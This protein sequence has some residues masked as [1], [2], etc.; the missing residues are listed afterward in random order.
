MTEREFEAFLGRHGGDPER[1]PGAGR[2]EALALL[3]GSGSARAILARHQAFERLFVLDAVPE[4]PPTALI[5][6]RAVAAGRETKARFVWFRPLRALPFGWPQLAGL[7]ACAAVGFVIGA[8]TPV[9]H[10]SMAEL[11]DY[12]DPAGTELFDE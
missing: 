6:A 1:W 12:A 4:P 11:A 2:G 8:A 5:V 3:A 9:H 7:A 10:G